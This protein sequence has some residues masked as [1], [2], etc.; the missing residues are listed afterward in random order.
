MI[1]VKF[2]IFADERSQRGGVAMVKYERKEQAV[3]QPE[4]IIHPLMFGR[5]GGGRRRDILRG[6]G[7]DHQGEG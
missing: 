2:E 5:K 6:T 3:P 4:R 7:N 1:V